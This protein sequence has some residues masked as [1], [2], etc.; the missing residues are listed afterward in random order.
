[1]DIFKKFI[2]LFDLL[3]MSTL[4][5]VSTFIPTSTPNHY[6]RIENNGD[7]YH[8]ITFTIENGVEKF[9][10]RVLIIPNN[11]YE[12]FVDIESEEN[13]N[14]EIVKYFNIVKKEHEKIN[15]NVH[16]ILYK[17]PNKYFL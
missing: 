15:Y 13:N 11:T 10:S 4:Y 12:S 14:L 8:V 3:K 17:Y 1:V 7:C 2:H 9:I 5:P 16:K 6:K